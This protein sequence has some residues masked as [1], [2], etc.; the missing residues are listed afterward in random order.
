MTASDYPYFQGHHPLVLPHRGGMDIVPENTLEALQYSDRNK[1]THFETDLRISKDGVVFLHHDETLNRTTSAEG[2]V[3]DYLWHDLLKINAGEKFYEKNNIKG[4][5]TVFISLE[6]ALSNFSNM[7]FNLDL[8]QS[9]MERRVLDIIMDS[10]ASERTLVSSFSPMR[11][12]KFQEINR[13][14][15]AISASIKQN[16]QAMFNSK[17]FRLWSIQVQALQIPIR[18]KGIKVLTKNLV[19]Y[20]HSK[21]IQVHVWTVND[22][23]VLEECLEIG[24]DGIMTDRPLEVRNFIMEKYDNR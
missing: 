10:N 22:L 16:L 6:D 14:N 2:K 7:K 24:C 3:S 15:I 20:A 1:F 9:G 18:W 11:L 8:K 17:F 19:E 4:K 12:R 13:Y 23:K 5:S 21:N